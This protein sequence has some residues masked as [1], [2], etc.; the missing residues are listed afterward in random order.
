MPE[1]LRQC[2]VVRA[3]KI[4]M[5][6]L[7]LDNYYEHLESSVGRMP[8]MRLMEEGVDKVVR[9]TMEWMGICGSA[10][11]AVVKSMS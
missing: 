7:V 2:V 4:D 5:N 3:H 9:Q 11:K 8:Q 6:R 1:L 10:G